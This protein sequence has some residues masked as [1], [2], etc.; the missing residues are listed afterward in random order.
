VSSEAYPGAGRPGVST[1]GVMIMAISCLSALLLIGALVY[2][3]GNGQRH[4]T[5]LAAADCEPSLSPP[6]QPCTTQPMMAA[7]YGTMLAPTSQQLAT[8]AAAYAANEGNHLAVAEAALTSEVA[9]ERA[10]G[11]SLA[12]FS[13]PPGIAP[14]AK[15]LIQAN[16]ARI[17]VTAE[18]ARSTS[19]TRL[20][21]S[22]HQVQLANAAVQTEMKLV[23]AAVDAPL[24]GA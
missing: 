3:A 6:G 10:L 16:Q 13:F 18:Q 20:R 2:A 17:T 11:R 4:T 7:E 8:D 22:S 12:A 24:P 23:A 14:V 19:L 15:G 1:G 5:A 21:S 9:A